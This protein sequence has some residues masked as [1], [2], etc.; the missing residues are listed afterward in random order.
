MLDDLKSASEI[1]D[2]IKNKKITAQ[3]VVQCFIERIKKFDPKIQAFLRF[4]EQ[5]AIEQAQK[6][7]KEH[8]EYKQA[9]KLIEK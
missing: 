7:S 5:K 8:L 9:A 2:S 3:E 1:I 6:T 4:D